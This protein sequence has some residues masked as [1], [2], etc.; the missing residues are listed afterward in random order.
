[1]RI[2]LLNVYVKIRWWYFHINPNYI[3]FYMSSESD[4]AHFQHRKTGLLHS[5]YVVVESAS[6]GDAL[7]EHF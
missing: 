5:N 2:F 3:K 1:M 4:E 6:D 7:E